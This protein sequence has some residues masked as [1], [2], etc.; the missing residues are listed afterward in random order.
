MK[1]I[2]TIKEGNKAADNF[3]Q[4]FDMTPQ[5]YDKLKEISRAIN[6]KAGEECITAYVHQI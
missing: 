3:T 5:E 2:V 4:E 6:S 1:V